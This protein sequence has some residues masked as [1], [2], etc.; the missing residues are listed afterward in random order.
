VGD[1]L[2]SVGTTD[3]LRKLEDYFAPREAVAG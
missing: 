1:V 2:I 3:E